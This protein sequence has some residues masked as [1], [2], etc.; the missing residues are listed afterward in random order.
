M[1][2]WNAARAEAEDEERLDSEERADPSLERIEQRK[3]QRLAEWKDRVTE[4]EAT[5]NNNFAPVV[6]DWRARVAQARS[7]RA[8]AEK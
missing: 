4:E 8:A 3:R 2:R 1:S 6:G 5:H 7:K